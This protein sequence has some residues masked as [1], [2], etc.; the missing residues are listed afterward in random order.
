M[1]ILETEGSQNVSWGTPSVSLE[2]MIHTTVRWQDAMEDIF[3]KVRNTTCLGK[4]NLPK[5]ATSYPP[6]FEKQ[7]SH[8]SPQTF[9][10]S[11]SSWSFSGE[12]TVLVLKLH[13]F[14]NHYPNVATENHGY[15][16]VVSLNGD[17]LQ[18]QNRNC[19]WWLSTKKPER[20]MS[21]K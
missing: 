7:A 12:I 16:N 3:G 9:F 14:S 20:K 5:W 18:M 19:L 6:L 17:A 10:K 8:I 15:W 21:P 11:T 13:S 2:N 1:C 4:I